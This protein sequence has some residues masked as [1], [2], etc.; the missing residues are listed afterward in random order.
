[1][2]DPFVVCLCLRCGAEVHFFEDDVPRG[3]SPE[4]IPEIYGCM[5]CGGYIMVQ[6]VGGKRVAGQVRYACGVKC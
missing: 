6:R 2:R 1:M 4:E 3:I 5:L